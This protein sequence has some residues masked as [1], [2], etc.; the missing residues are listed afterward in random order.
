MES[1]ALS[2]LGLQIGRAERQTDNTF[3]ADQANPD[4]LNAQVLQ[5]T[6]MQLWAKG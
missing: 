1:K 5:H 4:K 3:S 6:S 2:G